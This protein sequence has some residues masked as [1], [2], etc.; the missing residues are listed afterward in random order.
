MAD[1]IR[2]DM[3]GGALLV[4][5][6]VRYEVKIEVKAAYDPLEIT[7]EDV[8]RD[9]QA[10]IQR[11][12]TQ[13]QGMTPQEAQ[14]QVYRVFRFDLCPPCQKIYLQRPIPKRG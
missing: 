4:D 1:G 12:L 14:D 13:L 9:L 8:E 2:C 6:E 7:R 11:L 5:S 10:E 3:C